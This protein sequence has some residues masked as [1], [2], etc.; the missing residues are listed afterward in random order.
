MALNVNS[1]SITSVIVNNTEMNV[2][3][4][5][6]GGVTT[7]IYAKA[8][9]Y[10]KGSY[11]GYGGGNNPETDFTCSRAS[12]PYGHGAVGSIN[13]GDTIYYGDELYFNIYTIST[14]TL[15][16]QYPDS[17]HTLTVTSNVKG[18]DY[19]SLM[20]GTGTFML[21]GYGSADPNAI[22]SFYVRVDGGSWHLY[23][24]VAYDDTVPVDHQTVYE[25]SVV[26]VADVVSTG[27]TA[28][29]TQ[30]NPLQVRMEFDADQNNSYIYEA[31]P[32][33]CRIRLEKNTG[34][35]TIYYRN[36]TSGSWSS[37]NST[38]DLDITYNTTFQWYA[39]A[40]NAGYSR[41]DSYTSTSSYESFTVNKVITI[42]PTARQLTLPNS[43]DLHI[44]FFL[45]AGS[46]INGI[47]QVNAA[48]YNNAQNSIPN[49]I[50]E[51]WTSINK[52]S[53][54]EF[55]ITASQINNIVHGYNSNYYY[56]G[57][58]FQ[59]DW[60]QADANGIV[61]VIADTNSY[62]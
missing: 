3:A 20:I 21:R 32:K 7:Y 42:S 23:T 16:T 61:Y 41:N 19:V 46:A 35:G 33:K 2:V 27:Y 59:I 25:N 28:K 45:R 50:V 17:S 48:S 26:E 15:I 56:P 55:I 9:T 49:F 51:D 40:L 5:V 6:Q 57:G 31:V 37:T 29:Y 53:N 58:D 60:T 34:V 44:A 12:S 8:F 38:V 52:N 24:N 4:V 22:T 43:V 36:G 30:N 62:T 1:T 54:N 47:E 39:P 13:D 10:T 18:S 11:Y 14:G